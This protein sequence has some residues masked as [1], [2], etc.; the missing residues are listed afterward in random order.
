MAVQRQ[1]KWDA[2][3]GLSGLAAWF[4]GW[5]KPFSPWRLVSLNGVWRGAWQGSLARRVVYFGAM[6]MALG[7]LGRI[8]IAGDDRSFHSP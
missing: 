5:S 1:R 3:L 7:S 8:R 2:R 4:C 6:A